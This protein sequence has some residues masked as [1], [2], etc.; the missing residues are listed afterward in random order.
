MYRADPLKIGLW[1]WGRRGGGA[2]F[3]LGLARALA[4]RQDVALTIFLS[5]QN[6]LLEESRAVR[7]SLFLTNTYQSRAN[8]LSALARLPVLIGSF[9]RAAR[10]SDVVV[11]TMTHLFTPLVAR[12]LPVPFVPVIHD[13][14][15]HHGDLSL[16]WNWRLS[17]ELRAARAAVALSNHVANELQYR[18]PALPFLR[19]QLPALYAGVNIKPNNDHCFL[20]FGR[21]RPYKGLDLLRDAFS[22]LR[23]SYPGVRLRIV[24]EGDVEACAPGISRIPGVTVEERWVPD[25]EIPILLGAATAVVLP[26]KEASQSGVVPQALALGVPVVATAVGGLREQ[27]REG[28]GG[29]LAE[30]PTPKALAH[31][32]SRVLT[33]GALPALRAAARLAGGQHLDWDSEAAKLVGFLRHLLRPVQPNPAQLASGAIIRGSDQ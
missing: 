7:G 13:A 18:A 17:S 30:A 5:H 31:A 32:M 9:V 14:E 4:A 26:Y 25:V 24:G 33:P 29:L 1:Y 28:A 8:F 15:P 11:S 2:Q 6:E 27:V 10:A 23:Q 3:T 16:F 20:M 12:Y 21:I 22:C 19:M